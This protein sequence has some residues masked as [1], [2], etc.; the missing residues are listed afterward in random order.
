MKLFLKDILSERNI[1][2]NQLH[3]MTGIS[4]TTLDP[5]TKEDTVPSKTRMETLERICSNLNIPLSRIISF[6]E[7]YQETYNLVDIIFEKKEYYPTETSFREDLVLKIKGP[8]NTT[9]FLLLI[10]E[11][12]TEDYFYEEENKQLFDNLDDILSYKPKN[13]AE[14]RKNDLEFEAI[15]KIIREKAFNYTGKFIFGGRAFTLL[16]FKKRAEGMLNST[17]GEFI[18]TENDLNHSGDLGEIAGDPIF[19]NFISSFIENKYKLKDNLSQTLP[20]PADPNYFEL[21]G[22]VLYT[23]ILRDFFLFSIYDD[24]GN[25]SFNIE[26]KIKP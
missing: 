2:V 8:K 26:V 7:S 21:V 5:L 9:Y 22:E 6:D 4:R 12:K 17:K 18:I 14:E 25:K 13:P 20:T 16:S 11:Y 24:L 3:K 23:P 19:I 1:S 10:V 15:E